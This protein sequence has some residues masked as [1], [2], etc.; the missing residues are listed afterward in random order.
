MLSSNSNGS[1]NPNSNGSHPFA[2]HEQALQATFLSPAYRS[3]DPSNQA[4]F[5]TAYRIAAAICKGN[6]ERATDA[7]DEWYCQLRAT[8]KRLCDP[9]RP[10]FPWAYQALIRITL[11]IVCNRHP[12]PRP[13]TMEPA[14][15]TNA[16]LSFAESNELHAQVSHLPESLRIVI[17]LRCFHDLSAK[18]TAA[19]LG[20]TANAVGLRKRQAMLRLRHAYGVS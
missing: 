14:I 1:G 5:S 20:T 19:I 18:Q 12:T 13:L 4:L 7:V 11:R 8:A 3:D 10:M 9:S 15:D 17:E 6:D 16:S 2:S